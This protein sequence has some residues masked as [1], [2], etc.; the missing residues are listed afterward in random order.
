LNATLISPHVVRFCLVALLASATGA[1]VM[2]QPAAT[3]PALESDQ[4]SELTINGRRPLK[5]D[6][7]ALG[8]D[9]V[10]IEKTIPFI[11]ES[12]GK[13][14]I[15]QK[16]VLGKTITV[17][18][19]QPIPRNEALDLLFM[20]LQQ[21]DVAVVETDR[22]VS[23]R[24]IE[25]VDRQDVPVIGPAERV[26]HRRDLGNMYRKVFALSNGNAA[27]VGEIIGDSIPPYSKLLVDEESNQIIMLG[28][29]AML[30]RYEK[31]I[32]SLDR[33]SAVQ[34][35]TKTYRLRYADAELIVENIKEL[36]SDDESSSGRSQNPRDRMA[37]IMMQR[38]QGRGGPGG[39]GP[40]PEPESG[41]TVV[42]ENLR[43]TANVQ[44]NSVTVI[45]EQPVLD[46]IREQIEG[47]WDLPIP[48]EAV[49]PRIYDLEHSD[50][51][52]IKELLTALFEETAGTRNEPGS[53]PVGRL[54]GQFTFE[55][56]EE[57]NRLVVLSR[58][59]ENLNVIDEMVEQLDRPQTAGLPQLVELKHANAE[60]LAEQLNALL[61]ESGTLAQ[62]GRQ[63]SGLTEDDSGASPFASDSTSS[64]TA[65]QAIDE[66]IS[67][68]WQRARSNAD[69]REASNLVGK[70]RIVPVARQNAL[71]ILS[72]PEY[73]QSIVSLIEQL[74]QPG[75]QV[76]ISA[77]IA[78]I[79]LDDATV[80]GLRWSNS[81]GIIEST[82]FDNRLAVSTD[83]TG[84]ENDFLS[85]LFDTSVLNVNT[86]LTVILQALDERAAIQILSEPKIFTSDNQEANFFDGQDIPFVT[87]SQTT[88]EGNIVNSF[89]YRAVGIQ[90]RV[91]PRIT[92]ERNVDLRVNIELSSIRENETLFGGFIVDRRETTT[93]LIVADGQTVVISGILRQQEDIINRK[94]P[95]LGDLPLI[96]A[97]FRSTTR[98]S[99]NTELVAFI[100]PVVVENE[101]EIE[102]L[103]Q[104][105][106]DRLFEL[107]EELTEDAPT[108]PIDQDIIWGTPIEKERESEDDPGKDED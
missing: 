50:P 97:L 90:L 46:Q 43:A 19:D 33:P 82:N 77:V 106:R 95:L 70:M 53:E 1:P 34:L 92:K 80:L 60:D 58:N 56:I 15:P 39:R 30:Q 78:E 66:P 9:N 57:T 5:G 74:D 45:A 26:E 62:V 99:T 41:S 51:L 107:R 96:G 25:E 35:E 108:G 38:F 6:P 69:E 73:H 20:A 100:T 48:E 44:Q 40:E 63:E 76:L 105:Y 88:D 27:N 54:T 84:T 4:V 81:A 31:L 89:D 86:D 28:T 104:P 21:A 10:S 42:S 22:V 83:F 98:S 14:V 52:K 93:Q 8:F 12:T 94:V 47:H 11:V 18:N 24:L 7:V 16:S 72:P 91:R 55:A 32:D 13:V 68:W 17:I 61:S 3:P 49:V 101:E 103:N 87:D 75:R 79:T 29:V 64:T 36:Y 65:D 67:F 71:M 102:S 2:A 85:S 37:Q 23:L 59:V